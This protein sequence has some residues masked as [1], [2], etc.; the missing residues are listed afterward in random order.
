MN[1][2]KVS[3]DWTGT[4]YG[5]VNTNGELIMAALKA[6]V[7]KP[8]QADNLD[9]AKEGEDKMNKGEV[10]EWR[11]LNLDWQNPSEGYD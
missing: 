7:T 11:Y 8:E 5:F 10:K 6:A 3:S 4:H 9:E 1:N 2:E